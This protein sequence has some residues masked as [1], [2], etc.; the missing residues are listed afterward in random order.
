MNSVNAETLMTA[1][2]LGVGGFITFLA[3]MDE[4]QRRSFNPPRAPDRIFRCDNCSWV[5]TDDPQV[6][7]SRCPGCGRTNEPFHF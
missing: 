7:R 1:Y 3:V 5:Y 6:D 2:V 4:I